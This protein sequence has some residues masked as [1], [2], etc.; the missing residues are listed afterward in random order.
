MGFKPA[1]LEAEHLFYYLSI[2]S[3][4]KTKNFRLS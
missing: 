1:T 3:G 2:Q 4:L